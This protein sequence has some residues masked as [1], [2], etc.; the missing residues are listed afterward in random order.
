LDPTPIAYRLA[1]VAAGSGALRALARRFRTTLIPRA[2]R[3]RIYYD[4]FDG[5]IARRGGVLTAEVAGSGWT[6]SWRGENGEIRQRVEAADPPGFAWD[7]PAG[8]LRD[9]LEPVVRVR[10]LLPLASVER[11]ER[12]L[13]VEDDRGKTVLRV[14][15]ERGRATDPDSGRS[16]VIPATLRLHP[17]RG[18]ET[19]ASRAVEFLEQELGL[20]RAPGGELT[21]VLQVLDREPGGRGPGARRP[22]QP[23]MRADGAAREI[24]RGLLEA[25]VANHDGTVRALDSEFLHDFRVAVRR[26]RAALGQLK[27]VFPQERTR[28]FR[29]E[30]SWLGTV[31]GPARDLDVHALQLREQRESMAIRHRGSLRPLEDFVQRRLTRERAVLARHLESA[32][33]RDL[34][35]D[36]GAFLDEDPPRDARSPEAVRPIRELAAERLRRAFDRV[37]KGGRRVHGAATDDEMHR[38]RILCKKLRYL[39]EFF[40]EILEP[41]T[42]EAF[43]GR[44]KALQDTL[45][46][47]ND[48]RVQ[49]VTLQGWAGAMEDEGSAGAGTFVLIGRLVERTVRRQEKAR[50]RFGKRFADLADAASREAFGAMIEPS[51]S[52]PRATAEEA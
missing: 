20:E 28:H 37:L 18:Y 5:R 24:H 2:V 1:S 52:G 32:R 36:W 14:V 46:E 25:I 19:P 50:R 51:A 21:S 30:F 29:R 45:G 22:L 15:L 44:L 49:R 23:W 8:P 4:T 27:G 34:I 31:T 16:G 35:R 12:G 43:V 38:L 7:L 41:R 10:R 33:Y 47:Y 9:A 48:C 3:T 42:A 26:T 17:L 6:L 11:E 40:R 39:L 13:A